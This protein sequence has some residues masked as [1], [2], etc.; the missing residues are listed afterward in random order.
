MS[1]TAVIAMAVKL[2]WDRY[3]QNGGWKVWKN[4]RSQF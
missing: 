2:W 1:P 4:G 3:R